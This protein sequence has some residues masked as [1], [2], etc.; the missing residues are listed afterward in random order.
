MDHHSAMSPYCERNYSIP[1]P[2]TPTYAMAFGKGNCSSLL[3][4][5]TPNLDTHPFTLCKIS[6]NNKVC[7]GCRNKYPKS[8]AP[9]DD[10]C[11]KH[12][13]WR[14]YIP[15]GTQISKC[16]F[17]NAYYHF[18]PSCIKLRFPDFVLGH[19]QVPEDL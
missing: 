5:P 9:P 11:V 6:G 2:F 12:P 8:P 19:L 1:R 14:Q 10:L 4:T 18:N 3:S 13:E 15:E 7:A 16:H 17:G